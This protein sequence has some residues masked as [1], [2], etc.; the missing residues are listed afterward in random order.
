ML[1]QLPEYQK[2]KPRKRKYVLATQIDKIAPTTAALRLGLNA[3]RMRRDPDV[4]RCIAVYQQM[5]AELLP[6]RQSRPGR[7]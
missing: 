2:L 1:F 4:Q 7:A 3:A 6:G 5:L